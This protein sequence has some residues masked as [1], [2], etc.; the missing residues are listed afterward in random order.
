[1]DDRDGAVAKEEWVEFVPEP[2]RSR[3]QYSRGRKDRVVF[4]VEC[5]WM[6]EETLE[7]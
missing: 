5:R 4:A 1:V 6:L 3:R 7:E 2:T